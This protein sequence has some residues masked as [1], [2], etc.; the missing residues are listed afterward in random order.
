MSKPSQRLRPTSQSP[1][2]PRNVGN[3]NR[4]SFGLV[5]M[6]GGLRGRLPLLAALLVL[7][8]LLLVP[9]VV[10]AATPATPNWHGTDA[11]KSGDGIMTLTWL[12]AS[13]ATGYQYRYS[14]DSQAFFEIPG[15]LLPCVEPCIRTDWAST[16]GGTNHE[17]SKGTLTVGTTYFFQIRAVNT[18]D[19]PH[20][21]SNPSET[22]RGTQW[23]LPA[24]LSD[25]TAT[26]GNASGYAGLDRPVRW[27]QR[28]QLRLPPKFRQRQH[29][30]GLDEFPLHNQ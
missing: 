13:A 29:L 8:A 22:E 1:A 28:P 25:L 4:R 11:V 6:P 30:G 14:N 7:A 27:R 9:A 24:A 5:N 10:F 20:T 12:T 2:R 23:A 18:N 26:A 21:Y 17:I 15:N 19:D 16:D 3:G